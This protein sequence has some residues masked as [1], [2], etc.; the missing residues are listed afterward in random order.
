V[1]R[2]D[3]N[4]AREMRRAVLERAAKASVVI[5]AAAVADYRPSQP[6]DA[7]M[8]KTKGALAIDLTRNQD[9]LGELGR[10]KGSRLLVGFAAETERV[11]ANAREKLARKNLDLIVA[12][13]V[14]AA[15]SGFGTDTNRITILDREGGEEPLPLLSKDEA[16]DAILDRVA[17]RMDLNST[18]PR[19][20]PPPRRGRRDS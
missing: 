7:K 10:A 16:A 11:I 14:T 12:N 2:T 4:T 8:K 3:V 20:S 17:R 5:M 19:K 6:A 18:S 1:E 9:I 15:D 13:D